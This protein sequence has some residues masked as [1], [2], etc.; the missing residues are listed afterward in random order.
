MV[1]DFDRRVLVDDLSWFAVVI[2]EA[3]PQDF[4]ARHNGSKGLF[5]CG[6]I[7]R[8]LQLHDARNV[9]EWGIGL[10]LIQKP[11]PMLS[12]RKRRPRWLPV[13]FK[14]LICQ[15]RAQIFGGYGDGILSAHIRSF[16]DGFWRS[17]CSSASES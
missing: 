17:S 8:S 2:D 4:V 5:K 9:V 1:L 6:H 15:K 10:E 14:Q 3:R 16:S 13:F 11:E 12:R 7:K